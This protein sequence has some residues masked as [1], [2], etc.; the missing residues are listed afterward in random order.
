MIRDMI[1]NGYDADD[2]VEI[3]LGGFEVE[4]FDIGMM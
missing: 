1:A 2:A 3:A 4:R